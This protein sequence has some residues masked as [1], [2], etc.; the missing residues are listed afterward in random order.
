MRLLLVED[1]P[2]LNAMIA[3]HLRGLGY[4]VDAAAS[5]GAALTHID[6][7]TYDAVVLDLG[8][9]DMDGMEVLG[10]L[11]VRSAAPTLILTARDAVAHRVA[12]LNAGADDYIVKPFDLDEF[13]A[14]L[15]AV[16]RRPGLREPDR[17]SFGDLSFDAAN[18]AARVGATS[19]ELTPRE[20]A[21]IEILI[22]GGERVAV[23]DT[24][25][26]KLFGTVDENSGNALE[27]IVSR[28]RR[29]LAGA[30]SIVR[31]ETVRGIGYRLRAAPA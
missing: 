13:E 20:A 24:V 15:R 17:A 12:G 19:I 23:R 3:A 18:R 22:I 30:H 25:A 28:L 6:S 9:P 31:I 8:L 11:R 16:L 26:E 5:G 7:A 21:L 14:R 4:I 2:D 29:K 10:T 27:A 1:N